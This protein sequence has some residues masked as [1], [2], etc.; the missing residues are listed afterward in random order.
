M[1]TIVRQMEAQMKE[2]LREVFESPR[3]MF[4]RFIKQRFNFYPETVNVC[5]QDIDLYKS[6]PNEMMTAL[7]ARKV[8]EAL[9]FRENL[10]QMCRL[11]PELGDVVTDIEDSAKALL[12]EIQRIRLKIKDLEHIPISQALDLELSSFLYLFSEYGIRVQTD[13]I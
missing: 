10:R 5:D 9:A 7:K 2:G 12:P 8:Y 4:E 13:D 11:Y 6:F 3:A 1:N